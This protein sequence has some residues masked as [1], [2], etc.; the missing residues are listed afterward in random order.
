MWDAREGE[1]E[2]KAEEV[3]ASSFVKS[4]AVAWE[5]V[6]RILTMVQKTQDGQTLLHSLKTLFV[7]FHL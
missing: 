7:S 5:T 1:L 4:A 2:G 3:L 6:C